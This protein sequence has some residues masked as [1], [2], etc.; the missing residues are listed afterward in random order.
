VCGGLP[1]TGP[2]ACGYS[3]RPS[4]ASGLRARRRVLPPAS[5][6]SVS[7]PHTPI[8]VLVSCPGETVL[9]PTDPGG[10]AKR[11]IGCLGRWP[12]GPGRAGAKRSGNGA[13]RSGCPPMALPGVDAEVLQ[14]ERRA[15]SQISGASPCPQ[16]KGGGSPMSWGARAMRAVTPRT[17]VPI[18]LGSPDHGR[19]GGVSIWC[20]GG[21]TG[22][23]RP[24]RTSPVFSRRAG[25]PG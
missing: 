8:R 12:E 6:V 10:V 1:A 18:L 13:I 16:T 9:T 5:P 14:A 4:S 25:R 11:S 23:G 15:P 17:E 24:F 22:G 2:A 19:G 3:R 7:S 20:R 21:V